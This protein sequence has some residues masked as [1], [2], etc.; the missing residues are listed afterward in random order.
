M[1]SHKFQCKTRCSQ[2]GDSVSFSLTPNFNVQIGEVCGP[3]ICTHKPQKTPKW[4]QNERE[5]SKITYQVSSMPTPLNTGKQLSTFF[6]TFTGLETTPFS[7]TKTAM[8]LQPQ[9]FFS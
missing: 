1:L 4:L 5:N 8:N 9:V 2:K 7:T 3:Y 6:N